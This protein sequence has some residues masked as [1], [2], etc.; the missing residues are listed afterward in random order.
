MLIGIVLL[1]AV[2]I[3]GTVMTIIAAVAAGKG[4][5]YRYPLCIRL[6]K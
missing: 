3:F 4:Q 6:V 5:D 1:P 2:V